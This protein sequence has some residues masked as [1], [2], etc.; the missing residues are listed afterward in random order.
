MQLFEPTL[1]LPNEETKRVEALINDFTSRS[2]IKTTQPVLFTVRSMVLRN[3][4]IRSFKAS[5]I[6]NVFADLLVCD[7]AHNKI[8]DL[9]PLVNHVGR[10][11]VKLNLSHNEITDEI[12][13]F[14]FQELHNLEILDLSHNKINSLN[15]SSFTGLSSLRA[16]DLSHNKLTSF[17]C[18]MIPLLKVLNLAHNSFTH[19]H[20]DDFVFVLNLV[21]LVLDFNEL[22]SES[23][24][25]DS[26]RR[27]SKLEIL[28]LQ[29]NKMRFLDERHFQGLKRLD[30]LKLGSNLIEE[31]KDVGIFS[32][33]LT[34]LKLQN[35]QIKSLDPNL[36]KKLSNLTVC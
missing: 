31:V 32:S 22:T 9:K 26:F 20:R 6:K 18:C 7:L 36:F 29:N 35:N 3:K 14:T 34:K 33:E 1:L 16:L 27:L 13:Q 30:V 21:K 25:M 17:N 24:S 28:S 19:I 12:K 15:R 5:V 8:G 23:L 10:C 11:L 4:A 2:I